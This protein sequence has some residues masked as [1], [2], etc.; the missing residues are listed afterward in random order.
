MAGCSCKKLGLETIPFIR[1][2]RTETIPFNIPQ[3][4]THMTREPTRLTETTRG[5]WSRRRR[6]SGRRLRPTAAACRVVPVYVATLR[7][8]V[9]TPDHAR[10]RRPTVAGASVAS[11]VAATAGCAETPGLG[12][13]GAA[14]SPA[15]EESGR[16]SARGDTAGCGG[17]VR[18][19]TRTAGRS[20]VLRTMRRCWCRWRRH[21]RVSR[22]LYSPRRLRSW[23]SRSLRAVQVARRC[24]AKHQRSQTARR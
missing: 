5:K 17:G 1:F 13:S 22:W 4:S 7:A 20:A 2:L 23:A 16:D 14:R 24:A 9:P 12:K 8:G 19:R 15:R 10:T 3:R 18:W 6:G 11:S 21:S